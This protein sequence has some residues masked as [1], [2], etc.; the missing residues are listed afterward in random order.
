MRVPSGDHRGRALLSALDKGRACL[1]SMPVSQMTP[2][3]L[4]VF[5]SILIR[6]YAML[7]PSGEICGSA[8]HCRSNTSMGLSTGLADSA[9][10]EKA[11]AA[12]SMAAKP[13]APAA[14]AMRLLKTSCIAQPLGNPAITLVLIHNPHCLHEGMTNSRTDKT[15]ASKLQVF[16]HVIAV[17]RRCGEAAKVQRPAAQHPAVGELPDISVERT[18]ALADFQIR[19]GVADESVP[20]QPI[21]DDARV[22]HQALALRRAVPGHGLGIEVVERLTIGLALAEHGEPAQASLRTL[23]TQ[24]FEEPPVAVLGHSP[25]PIVIVDVQRI[26]S[27]P[28]AAQIAVAA[29]LCGCHAHRPHADLNPTRVWL[30]SQYG[31]LAEAPQRHR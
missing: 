4:S 1:P 11:A 13:R 24:H 10:L 28:G 7:R 18:R 17:H 3:G 29:P 9:A 16:A 19:A 26:G 6:T 27:A 5:M 20:L 21:S 8:T 15:E 12:S 23:E 14:G 30:P 22:L 25:F 31:L 2:R